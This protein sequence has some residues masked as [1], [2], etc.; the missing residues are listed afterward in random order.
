MT[1]DLSPVLTPLMQL[2]GLGLMV[3]GGVVLRRLAAKL[4]LDANS[5]IAKQL[6]DALDKSIAAGAMSASDMIKSR[7]WD[8]PEVKNVVVASAARYLAAQWPGLLKKAGIDVNNPA[9][10]RERIAA[11]LTRAFPTAMAPIA[12]SPVTPPAPAAAA[13]APVAPAAGAAR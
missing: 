9:Y 8:H 4:G 13:A 10:A 5:T 6:D 2:A 12:A 3:V 11:L 1:V 7:G